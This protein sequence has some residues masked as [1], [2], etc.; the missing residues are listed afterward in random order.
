MMLPDAEYIE[1][2]LVGELD[3]LDE[4]PQALLGADQLP[5]LRVRV[6]LGEREETDLHGFI[7]TLAQRH[8]FRHR[9]VSSLARMPVASRPR[10]ASISAHVP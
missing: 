8:L 5:G 9:P 10:S 1:P 4:V 3:L 7:S 2:E 6:Q